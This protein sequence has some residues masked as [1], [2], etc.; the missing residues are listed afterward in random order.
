MN[1]PLDIRFVRC[2]GLLWIAPVIHIVRPWHVVARMP[3]KSM[4]EVLL[5]HPALQTHHHRM[6]RRRARMIRRERRRMTKNRNVVGRPTKKHKNKNKKGSPSPSESPSSSSSSSE[7]LSFAR[8][9]KK[10][11]RKMKK[12]GS[13]T[14]GQRGREDSDP[15]SFLHLK[16]IETG[17]LRFGTTCL[18]RPQSRT[19]PGCG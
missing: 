1:F 16:G 3:R 8:K 7:D 13:W 17:E 11:L 15:L 2:K 5:D 14:E 19:R 10:L 4:A 18:Q 12:R 9:V 6:T